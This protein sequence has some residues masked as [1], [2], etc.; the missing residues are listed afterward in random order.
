MKKTNMAGSIPSVLVLGKTK[1]L[2]VSYCKNVELV[3]MVC[4]FAVWDYILYRL[5]KHNLGFL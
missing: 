1:L 2:L 5:K 3:F 4:T